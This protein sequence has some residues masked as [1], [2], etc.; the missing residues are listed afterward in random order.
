[1][2]KRAEQSS[3]AAVSEKRRKF[4]EL[5]ERRTVNAIKAVRVIGKLGNRSHYEFD[6][7]DVRKII[8]AITKELESLRSKMLTRGVRDTVDFKL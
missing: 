5:A 7:A 2:P 1:M 6:E 8:Q 4:V 3:P